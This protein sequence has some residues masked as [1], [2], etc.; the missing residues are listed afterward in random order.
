MQLGAARL[1]TATTQLGSQGNLVSR[2]IR[3]V[4]HAV[5]TRLTS[6]HAKATRRTDL[7]VKLDPEA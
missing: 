7:S 5:A 2:I 6:L 4:L 1:G 3:H